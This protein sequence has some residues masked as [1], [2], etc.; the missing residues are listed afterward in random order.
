MMLDEHRIEDADYLMR[1][2][3]ASESKFAQLF[4]AGAKI[5]CRLQNNLPRTEWEL[6]ACSTEMQ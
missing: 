4:S 3:A 5:F 6:A 1:K 2:R